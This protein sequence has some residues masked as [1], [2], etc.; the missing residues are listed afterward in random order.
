MLMREIESLFYKENLKDL[1]WLE[2]QENSSEG[3]WWLPTNTSEEQ[4][5]VR[6]KK[7]LI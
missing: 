3:I 6:R 7:Y 5:L 1:D 2:Q 4:I